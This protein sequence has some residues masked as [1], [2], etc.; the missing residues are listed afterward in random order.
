MVDIHMYRSWS[1]CSLYPAPYALSLP[2]LSTAVGPLWAPLT[3]TQPPP[4]STRA[5]S[6]FLPWGFVLRLRSLFSLRRHSGRGQELVSL[7]R[8]PSGVHVWIKFPPSE[9]ISLV[10]ASGFPRGCAAA[11][12]DLLI[13]PLPC[14]SSCSAWNSFQSNSLHAGSPLGEPGPKLRPCFCFQHGFEELP[15]L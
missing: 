9:V 6:A 11:P 4:T 3:H 1:R 14:P 13:I 10:H 8:P 7:G 15:M 2:A 12:S 5:A